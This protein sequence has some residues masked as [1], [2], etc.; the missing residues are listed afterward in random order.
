MSAF[1]RHPGISHF[2]LHRISSTYQQR[3]NRI[4]VLHTSMHPAGQVAV[5]DTTFHRTLA[6]EAYMYA[7]PYELYEQHGI[8]R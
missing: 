5:F 3:T 6:P 8:R 7:L 1:H 4:P 2:H